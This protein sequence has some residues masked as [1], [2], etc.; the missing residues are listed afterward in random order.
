MNTIHRNRLTRHQNTI[1]SCFGVRNRSPPS[2][3][4]TSRADGNVRHGINA[5]TDL[6]VGAHTLVASHS[7]CGCANH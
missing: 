6:I 3:G 5:V 4:E 2:G 7:I 1:I